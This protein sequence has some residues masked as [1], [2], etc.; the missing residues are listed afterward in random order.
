MMSEVDRVFA[1]W[2]GIDDLNIFLLETTGFDESVGEVDLVSV[3]WSL[4]P[5]I[6]L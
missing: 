5:L 1:N 6:Y 2:S 3:N 4:Y